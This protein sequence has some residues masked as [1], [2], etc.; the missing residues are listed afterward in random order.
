MVG[1][2]QA[3][4]LPPGVLQSPGTLLQSCNTLNRRRQ[5]AWHRSRPGERR[6]PKQS[7]SSQRLLRYTLGR[8][9]PLR[10]PQNRWAASWQSATHTAIEAE[11]SRSAMWSVA[12]H[13]AQ[14]AELAGNTSVLP[15]HTHLTIAVLLCR[16]T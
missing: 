7:A 2:L 16:L 11:P 9:N 4:M 12:L 3:L 15:G 5:M 14:W 10:T 1:S 13:Q 8:R 6:L